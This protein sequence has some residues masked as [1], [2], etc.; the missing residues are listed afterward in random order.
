MEKLGIKAW[1]NP[2]FKQVAT[3]WLA[4]DAPTGGTLKIDKE[5]RLPN[6]IYLFDDNFV[7]PEGQTY[8]FAVS[9]VLV[10]L[11]ANGNPV[12][13]EKKDANGNVVKNVDG[14][15]IMIEKEETRSPTK[16]LPQRNEAKLQSANIFES[17][18]PMKPYLRY[19]QKDDGTLTITSSS[20]LPDTATIK[21]TIWFVY[22]D[23]KM[24]KSFVTNGADIYTLKLDASYSKMY[25]DIKVVA[26]HETILGTT[27][28]FGSITIDLNI[29]IKAESNTHSLSSY[30]DHLFIYS[31]K[32]N[33]STLDVV[34]TI[35][36]YRNSDDN[37]IAQY[38]PTEAKALAIKAEHLE[39]G[40]TYSL[41]FHF[42]DGYTKDGLEYEDIF[43]STVDEN[44]LFFI[45]EQHTYRNEYRIVSSSSITTNKFLYAEKRED[46]NYLGFTDNKLSYFMMEN[47]I[48]K[49]QYTT[50]YVLE[51]FKVSSHMISNNLVV[52]ECI[53]TD[54]A[55]QS[56]IVIIRDDS[57]T[58]TFVE[59][60]S[61]NKPNLE[62]RS[63]QIDR[64]EKKIYY[65]DSNLC[66]MD[67]ENTITTLP[68]RPDGII[69]KTKLLPLGSG[70]VLVL[71]GMTD[72]VYLY[73]LANTSYEFI[74]TIPQELINLDLQAIL[75][76]DN[77]LIMFPIN[78]TGINNFAMTYDRS[79]FK[80]DKVETKL[81]PTDGNFFIKS[82][83]V[84]VRHNSIDTVS[85]FI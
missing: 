59:V 39:L 28:P 74:A 58:R 46:G 76:I 7:I 34:K 44:T 17:R 78:L 24:L 63:V 1:S 64:I 54:D 32:D 53:S 62:E 41:R 21:E 77:K 79:T 56:K 5:V 73:D 30:T 2:H 82:S 38:V 19:E 55:V 70:R 29:T 22:K 6:N 8:Y 18:L 36:L 72:N 31:I 9:R 26:I 35:S 57:L 50:E 25:D 60:A 12:L 61:F 33:L 47:G 84:I 40:Q 66:S 80:L 67:L 71:G 10:P 3:K 20:I 27:S 15:P 23:G 48:S 37:F 45:D 75:R 65:V 49:H 4:Y 42:K 52:L 69:T 11:D 81:T 83:G 16:R 85:Y 68:A 14:T 43:I 51:N 13:V